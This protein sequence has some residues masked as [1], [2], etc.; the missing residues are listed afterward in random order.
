[1]DPDYDPDADPGD[2]SYSDVSTDDEAATG[3]GRSQR[4][5]MS[6]AVVTPLVKE[7][8]RVLYANQ[9]KDVDDLGFNDDRTCGICTNCLREDCG[10]CDACLDNDVFRNPSG[11]ANAARVCRERICLELDV[12]EMPADS[13]QERLNNTQGHHWIRVEIVESLINS[14]HPA[15][16][17]DGTRFEVGDFALMPPE[18]GAESSSRWRIGRI[19]GLFR[20]S[21]QNLAHVQF[22]ARGVNTV[23]GMLAD[24]KELFETLECGEVYLR[25]LRRRVHVTHRSAERL[26]GNSGDGCGNQDWDGVADYWYRFRYDKRQPTFITAPMPTKSSKPLLFCHLSI[27]LPF[28]S[29]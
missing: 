7:M 1:M 29:P 4:H 13:G 2:S 11:G 10:R 25:D 14:C 18:R 26:F 21:G 8:F 3:N 16:L 24:E 9:I 22:F 15:A 23:L 12:A 28:F 19:M 6:K 5:R 17:V 27:T 20:H